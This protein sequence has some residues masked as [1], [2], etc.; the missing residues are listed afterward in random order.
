MMQTMTALEAISL[1]VKIM[2]SMHRQ[3]HFVTCVW[4]VL[5]IACVACSHAHADIYF[6]S[7]SGIKEEDDME[8]LRAAAAALLAKCNKHVSEKEAAINQARS[9][10][11]ERGLQAAVAPACAGM[12]VPATC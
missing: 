11:A 3:L 12:P 7:R 5:Q 1:H 2:V 4:H 9:A 10:C 8:G 6:A